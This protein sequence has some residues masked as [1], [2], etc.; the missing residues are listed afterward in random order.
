MKTLLALRAALAAGELPEKLREIEAFA[1]TDDSKLLMTA[2]FA[3][4]PSATADLATKF[5]AIVPEIESLLFHEPGRERMELHGPGFVECKV[6]GATYRVGHFSFFQ[7]NRFLVDELVREVVES[8]ANSRLAVDLFA[9]VGLFSVPLAKRFER[10]VAVEANPAAARDLEANISDSAGAQRPIR[11]KCGQRK[12]KRF[13]EKYREKPQLI[14]LDPPRA[15]LMPGSAKHLARIGPAHITYISC[16]PPTLA[17]DLAA[18]ADA[19][20]DVSDVHL[21]DLF[22]QTFHMETVVR[23]RRRQ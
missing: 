18:L 11:S 9:G 16:D 5:R 19:G 6:G 22:P 15:G 3:G 1:N 10:I 21:F 2:I 8:E 4:F 14:V 17:R 23:L 13:L 12:W 7:V 20:Y